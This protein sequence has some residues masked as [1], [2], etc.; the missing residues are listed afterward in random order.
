MGNFRRMVWAT[1]IFV[2]LLAPFV[3]V[4]VM[5][6]WNPAP[7]RALLAAQQGGGGGG[8]AS[9]QDSSP[10]SP[11]MI[12]PPPAMT[13]M[14]A[15]DAPLLAAG[16]GK[17]LWV[18][19]PILFEDKD[20]K[21]ASYE[22]LA[23]SS[24]TGTWSRA[25]TDRGV[26]FGG[27]PQ[28][29]ATIS[30]GAGNG[31]TPAYVF[32]E[33]CITRF[34][35]DDH[36]L[37]SRPLPVDQVLLSEGGGEREM[38][39]VTRGPLVVAATQPVEAMDDVPLPVVTDMAETRPASAPASHP[40]TTRAA[41]PVTVNTWWYRDDEWVVLPAMGDGPG[42]AATVSVAGM[43]G[44]LVV[45]W[46]DASRPET[47][48]ARSI[49]YRGTHPQWSA[50]ARSDLRGEL[51]AN[52]HLMTV[53]LDDTLYTFWPVIGAKSTSLHGGWVVTAKDAVAGGAADLTLPVKNLLPQL[54]LGATPVG[55][56]W[57]DIAIGPA[58]NSLAVIVQGEKGELSYQLFTNRGRP[59]G[60]L[61]AVVVKS[62]P[63]DLAIAQN[64][65]ML[66]LMLML[67][68][69]IWQWRQRP[70]MGEMPKD[71]QIAALHLRAFAFLIDIAIPFIIVMG[72]FGLGDVDT[73][74]SAW[75]DS[76]SNPE[77]LL[78][79]PTLLYTLGLYLAHVT[80]GELFFRR[81]I[82]KA[83][84]GLQVLMMDGKA[85][86]VAA[87]LLRNLVRIPELLPGILI[88]YV[89]IS[90]K[91]Q[92]L[93]DVLARTVVVAQKAPEMPADPDVKEVKKEEAVG[94]A[95]R[96]RLR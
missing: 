50:I 35:L 7:S 52:A 8:G 30:G 3:I 84:L 93:G 70:L 19:H 60:A 86:T 58:E 61:A 28:G 6:L 92:R 15:N 43:S 40:V 82:G 56:K 34:T 13:P 45:L 44:R 87:I 77:E 27:F 74:F 96:E 65:A 33:G 10:F 24:N 63:R 59:I 5:T 85:P 55:T 51:P 1:V 62:V 89:L 16:D 20:K 64:V 88:L 41:A 32:T 37:L 38:F 12:V 25:G 14:D 68:L 80:I 26:Y 18:V 47:L 76:F 29:L 78:A 49:D 79:A 81:S 57:T 11:L 90:D 94:A 53:V 91:H 31:V 71:L 72:I 39:A 66:L 48:Q 75:A 21:T 2:A 23:R 17:T 95:K 4:L 54:A 83:I 22:L 42:V 46:E 73:L 69:S 36:S 67:G 9:A